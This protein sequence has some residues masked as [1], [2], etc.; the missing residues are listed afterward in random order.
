MKT[1]ILITIIINLAHITTSTKITNKT[2]PFKIRKQITETAYNCDKPEF[3][4]T[5]S[6][7]DLYPVE[8]KRIPGKL[9]TQKASWVHYAT[10]ASLSH[11]LW[12]QLPPTIILNLRPC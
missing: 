1:A 6:L 9:T 5:I 7:K 3:E 4:K 2:K 8:V 11:P 10:N 12:R